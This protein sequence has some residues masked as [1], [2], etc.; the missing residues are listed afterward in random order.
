MP[1]DRKLAPGCPGN[2]AV[3]RVLEAVRALRVRAEAENATLAVRPRR[4]RR[5]P[6]HH[7][8]RHAL[9]RD[10]TR[11]GGKALIVRDCRITT[12]GEERT[13]V[14]VDSSLL[15]LNPQ[16]LATPVR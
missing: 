3:D 15:T 4:D 2:T 9:F 7:T 6:R 16:Q 10:L 8:P 14:V 13:L 11:E 12:G 1:T 5:R